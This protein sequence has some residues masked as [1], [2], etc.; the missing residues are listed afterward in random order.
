MF[1]PIQKAAIAALTGSLEGVK[2]QCLAYQARR[3]ALCGGLRAIGWN[4][5]DSRGTMFA[6]AHIPDGFSS[7]QDF[8]MELMERTGVICTPG[9]AFGSQGEGYVRFALVLPVETIQELIAVIEKSGVLS[10]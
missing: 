2:S 10:R 4:V 6:W 9:D 5:P 7:S 1:A 8:C 3:D